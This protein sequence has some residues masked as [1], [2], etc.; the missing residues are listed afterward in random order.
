MECSRKELE[1]NRYGNLEGGWKFLNGAWI[2]EITVCSLAKSTEYNVETA[3][4]LLINQ[5]LA[6]NNYYSDI[7]NLNFIISDEMYGN[8]AI[9]DI[10]SV[11]I[12]NNTIKLKINNLKLSTDKKVSFNFRIWD[13]KVS[14]INITFFLSK[15]Q[16]YYHNINLFKGNLN[17]HEFLT[18]DTI[19]YISDWFSGFFESYENA[20]L[21]ENDQF[22]VPEFTPPHLDQIPNEFN[23]FGHAVYQMSKINKI[24]FQD[25]NSFINNNLL[26]FKSLCI[27]KQLIENYYNSGMP[28]L[29]DLDHQSNQSQSIKSIWVDNDYIPIDIGS[30]GSGNFLGVSDKAWEC[31]NKKGL[32]NCTKDPPSYFGNVHIWDW[33]RYVNRRK[34]DFDCRAFSEAMLIF[35]R[36]QLKDICPNASV[37]IATTPGHSLLYVDLGGEGDCCSG[38]FFLEATSDGSGTT[39]GPNEFPDAEIMDGDFS[40]DDDNQENRTKWENDESQLDKLANIVCDCINEY[41]EETNLSLGDVEYNIKGCCDNDTIKEYLRHYAY[42]D[43]NINTPSS[44]P[45]IIPQIPQVVGCIKYKC[46]KD[47]GCVEDANTGNLTEYQCRNCLPKPSSNCEIVNQV[48]LALPAIEDWLQINWNGLSVPMTTYHGVDDYWYVDGYID[49][50]YCILSAEG[51]AS[52]ITDGTQCFIATWVICFKSSTSSTCWFLIKIPVS[53]EGELGSPIVTTTGTNDYDPN[54]PIICGFQQPVKHIF[55]NDCNCSFESPIVSINL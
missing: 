36:N 22:L 13:E 32:Y 19:D 16:I 35:L 11:F 24:Q 33:R 18:Q 51:G 54:S 34:K 14:P 8:Y 28:A 47:Q 12:E 48:F 43:N 30:T 53:E 42:G 10:V 17:F 7:N 20:I 52:V 45:P 6:N 49:G 31:M 50:E 25:I 4:V 26:E 1:Q 46:I 2:P 5:T 41:S 40:W 3:V 39:Y 15:N 29:I 44:D 27:N 23:P 9:K 21:E 37:N 55:P 38:S